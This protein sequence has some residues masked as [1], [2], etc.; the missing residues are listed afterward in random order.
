MDSR[1]FLAKQLDQTGQII[2]WAISLFSEER[3]SEEP[4]HRTHPN[5]P[6]GIE[7]FFGKW[8][9]L[10]VLFHLLYYEE[11]IVLPSLKHWVGEPV[12]IYPKSSE[13]E[14]EWKKCDNKTKL[15]DRF[16]EVRKRQL[17]IIN[18]IDPI[19]WDNDKLVYHGH[20]KV[21]AYWFV[22]KTIQHTFAHG[23]KLLRKA[24]YWDDF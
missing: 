6:E 2:E 17:E 12:P 13:E 21:S 7:S 15:L 20:G 9:A 1:A 23:D 16:R 18:R 24:L 4:S 3:L 11:T 22:S 10:R 5:A 19:D 14:Q 8:S